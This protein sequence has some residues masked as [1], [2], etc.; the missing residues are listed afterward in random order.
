MSRARA[1]VPM[2]HDDRATAPS[3]PPSDADADS[4][5]PSG[6]TLPDE[7]V[8]TLDRAFRRL[9]K[10]LVKPPAGLVPVPSL[11]RQVEFAKIAACDAIAE[12]ADGST[13]VSVK[14]VALVLQ[15]EHSTVSRLLSE[16]EDDG[17]LV[18]GEHPHDR[19]R[20]TVELTD[21]G[22]AVV[23]D[24]TAMT[25]FFT[26]ALLADWPVEDVESLTTLLS[27]LAT[28]VHERLAAL[29]EL[30]MTEFCLPADLHSPD[31]TT[32]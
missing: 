32:S 11:G 4:V 31:A 24:A 7:L 18:R 20:T 19:R 13:S 17:L 2:T 5:A 27:R 23:A 1:T 21:L 15:L 12:L 25:R 26:R 8:D 6:G 14:D 10:A 28:S 16:I 9:R 29:P 22:R 30:A 3:V